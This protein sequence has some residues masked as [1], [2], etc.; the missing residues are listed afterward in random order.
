MSGGSP[1]DFHTMTHN[2]TGELKDLKVRGEQMS[3]EL[4]DFFSKKKY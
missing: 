2:M 3:R 1:M 4:K